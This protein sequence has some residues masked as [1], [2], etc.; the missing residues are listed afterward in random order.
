MMLRFYS[1]FKQGTEGQCVQKQ[2]SMF[3]V[4]NRAKWEAWNA[5]GDMPRDTAM[6]RYVDELK[7]IVETMSFTE[8]VANFVGS[9]SELDNIDVSD[10]EKVAPEA[11]AHARSR[12]GSPFGSGKGTPTHSHNIMMN[13]H[14]SPA[15]SDEEFNSADEAELPA[16]RR[17]AYQQMATVD[18]VV[19]QLSDTLTSDIRALQS[20]FAALE[21]NVIELKKQQARL[22][23]FRHLYPSWWPLKEIS[24]TVL[25]LILLWPIVVNRFLLATRRRSTKE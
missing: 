4:V 18:P 6:Q 22:T 20:K 15:D 10:L 25:L 17:P 11:M 3:S 1:L 16:M 5:L 24:P 13:G 2:P 9:I 19:R 23:A 7:K 12:P 14:S 8:N 21:Q